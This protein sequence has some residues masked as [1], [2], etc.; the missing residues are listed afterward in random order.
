MPR[1][2]R[3]PSA[4]RSSISVAPA[5]RSCA[6]SAAQIVDA[7]REMV[8]ALAAPREEASDRRVVRE[9]RQQLDAAALAEQQR[10][11]LDALLLDA[12]APLHARAVEPL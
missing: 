6:S 3:C 10:E 1:H 11:R 9:R 2:R 7:E 5:A 12:L 4:A 8:H